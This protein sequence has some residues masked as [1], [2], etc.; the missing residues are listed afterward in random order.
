MI[1][2]ID[3]K[4]LK[5]YFPNKV[6][7]SVDD[8]VKENL[9]LKSANNTDV[10]VKGFV[11]VNFCVESC[12]FFVPFLVIKKVLANPVLGFNVIAYMISNVNN[13]SPA[14]T[15][16]LNISQMNAETMINLIEAGGKT[17]DLLGEIKIVETQIYPGIYSC[18]N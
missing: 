17:P 16:M 2:L 13:P 10:P 11:I 3:E 12:E 14:L 5:Q 6:I 7:Y 9:N 8:F 18:S 15:S 4:F 1:S